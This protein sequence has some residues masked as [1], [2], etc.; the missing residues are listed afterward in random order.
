MEAGVVAGVED[1][2]GRGSVSSRR[3]LACIK[4]RTERGVGLL[5]RAEAKR[6]PWHG[7]GSTG[8]SIASSMASACLGSHG[9]LRTRTKEGLQIGGEGQ[10]TH[11]ESNGGDDEAW[12]LATTEQLLFDLHG[13]RR[14]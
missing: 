9:G 6:V 13:G 10:G 1:G 5:E 11:P 8:A 3:S 2:V 4:T 12:E 7:L 14:S